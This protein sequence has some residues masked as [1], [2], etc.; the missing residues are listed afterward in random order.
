[1]SKTRPIN[2]EI[3]TA[4]D[5]KRWFMKNPN[6]DSFCYVTGKVRSF[7]YIGHNNLVIN[8]KNVPLEFRDMS[9]GV[10]IVTIK[11]IKTDDQKTESTEGS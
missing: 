11:E 2:H 1:M 3:K 8:N 9:G 4:E 10:W 5:L 7:W 6:V